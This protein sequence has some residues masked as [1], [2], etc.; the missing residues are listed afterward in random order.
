MGLLKEQCVE[1]KFG[2]VRS[3]VLLQSGLDAEV[4]G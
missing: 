1:K 2:K 4:V 3:A